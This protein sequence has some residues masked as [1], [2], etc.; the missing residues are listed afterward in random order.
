MESCVME[1]T[2]MQVQIQHTLDAVEIYLADARGREAQ[3]L[4]ALAGSARADAAAGTIRVRARGA[5]LRVHLA[6]A[7]L[8]GD[9]G[10]IGRVVEA[11]CAPALGRDAMGSAI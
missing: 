10:L 8:T 5:S 9:A 11:A 4:R 3:V 1:V 2:A 6:A 7:S